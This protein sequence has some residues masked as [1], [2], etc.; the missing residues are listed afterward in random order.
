MNLTREQ[1][2]KF[3]EESG[4]GGNQRNTYRV[5]L[6]LFAKKVWAEA[7]KELDTSTKSV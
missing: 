3:A 2:N 7:K 6:E 5:K 4:F 1:I